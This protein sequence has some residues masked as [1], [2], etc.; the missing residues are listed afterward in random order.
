MGF[1]VILSLTVPTYSASN[2]FVS[3]F[4]F[5]LFSHWR[6]MMLNHEK[7]WD[8]NG[9]IAYTKRTRKKCMKWT[10][11]KTRGIKERVHWMQCIWIRCVHCVCIVHIFELKKNPLELPSYACFHAQNIE[12]RKY[13]TLLLNLYKSV[14]H[15]RFFLK[16]FSCVY[17]L[18]LSIWISFSLFPSR[19]LSASRLLS[20]WKKKE[21]LPISLLLASFSLRTFQPY[22]HH[23]HYLMLCT[24]DYYYIFCSMFRIC[25]VRVECDV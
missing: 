2:L 13:I 6:I 3:R 18:S 25:C 11:T 14:Q 1:F 21:P 15:I 19:K 23:K 7:I 22:T 4:S 24:S 12:L 9:K 8:D 20:L 10:I 5:Q 16:I 17:S